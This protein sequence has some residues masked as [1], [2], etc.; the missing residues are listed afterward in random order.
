MRWWGALSAFVL[1]VFIAGN[2]LL[3]GYVLTLDMVWTPEVPLSWRADEP[4]NA[5]VVRSFL[6]LLSQIIPSWMVQ[7]IL[8]L[9]M[10]V[11]LFYVPWRFLP[12]IQDSS[13]RLFAAGIYALNPFVYSR[14]LAGQ[15]MLLVGYALL[16]C[17]LYAL[18]RYFDERSIRSALWLA[19]SLFLVSLFSVHFFY[20]AILMSTVWAAAHALNAWN[21]DRALLR[22]YVAH[23]ALA[24]VTVL[25]L[26]SWW[27]IPA[28]TRESP[29][30]SRFDPSYFSAF[31]ASG[32]GVMGVLLNVA[33]LG[34]FWGEDH[35]WR[36]YFVWP[37]DSII[38]WGAFFVVAILSVVGITHLFMRG[39]RFEA[40]LIC[41][42]G[43]FS[44]VIALGLSDTPAY[45]F[46]AFLYEHLPLMEGLRDSHK[47]AGVLALMYAIAS[48]MGAQVLLK[49]ISKYAPG[50]GSFAS[51]AILVIPAAI[52]L[53]FWGG[54]N[55][56]LPPAQYPPEWFAIREIIDRL[57]DTERVLV[58]PW[59]GYFSLPFADNRVVAN[60]TR[61]FFGDRVIA[62]RG[63]EIG[64]VSDQEI[65]PA[66]RDIDAFVTMMPQQSEVENYT[67]LRERGISHIIIIS[68]PAIPRSEE[69]M[70]RWTHFTGTHAHTEQTLL[71][72]MP[73]L[74]NEYI[75]SS[76]VLKK[77]P[78]AL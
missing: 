52:G 59:H 32:N 74:A 41:I 35:A 25:T 54:M 1:S 53:F 10:L 62:G 63:I 20:L 70:I 65:N 66:Y 30:E 42:T 11:A 78:P 27:L 75:S 47:A 38:F 5:F 31:S 22:S 24:V 71:D 58:L 57:P 12:F 50:V 26:C 29:L 44:Y 15:W 28:L 36:Y 13:A 7:K 43:V 46:N 68:N 76:T 37:Q 23:G 16:P 73:T 61:N 4:N 51:S 21:A 3:Q 56:Q 40:L 69:G 9:G 2:M 33:A 45:A 72:F 64:N 18:M 77:I 17:V 14:I 34:G 55:G 19:G 67:A 60:P 6:W 49:C 48:G 39:K 8:L